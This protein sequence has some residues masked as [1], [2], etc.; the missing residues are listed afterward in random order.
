MQSFTKRGGYTTRKSI[1]GP[2]IFH[3][4]FLLVNDFKF[5]HITI[6]IDGRYSNPLYS[7]IVV[8]H[9][10]YRGPQVQWLS[11][12]C[13]ECEACPKR[14]TKASWL[15]W[16]CNF[17]C[18]HNPLM[19]FILYF[20]WLIAHLFRELNTTCSLFVLNC[21]QHSS[22]GRPDSRPTLLQLPIFD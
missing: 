4:V 3:Y 10:D 20:E 17:K 19:C 9:M 15:A 5:W 22:R 14:M 21:T 2:E 1:T 12:S 8:E 11:C 16:I 7:W 13:L 6:G 18:K